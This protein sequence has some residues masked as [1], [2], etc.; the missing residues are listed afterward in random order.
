MLGHNDLKT[1]SIYVSLAREQMN[2]DVQNFAL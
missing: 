2:K 1:T